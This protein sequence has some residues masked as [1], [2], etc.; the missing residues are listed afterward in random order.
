MIQKF[1]NVSR[2]IRRVLFN[3]SNHP[4][5]NSSHT[6]KNF[7]NNVN[8]IRDTLN[9]NVHNK[10]EKSNVSDSHPLLEKILKVTNDHKSIPYF[11]KI[12]NKCSEAKINNALEDL[13][14]YISSGRKVK[15][16]GAFFTS[17]INS[18]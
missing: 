10:T 6:G 9:V 15:N 12:I 18:I 8:T 16:A 17:R 3:L 2:I 1:K 14:T 4:V 13:Q 7:R 11:K 5:D